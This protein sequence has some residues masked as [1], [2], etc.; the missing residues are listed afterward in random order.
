MSLP[1]LR[2]SAPASAAGQPHVSSA[3]D[4]L[5]R[6]HADFVTNRDRNLFFGVYPSWE[7]AEQAAAAYGAAGYDNA[8]SAQLYRHRVRMD[9]HDYPVLAWLLRSAVEGHRRVLDVGGATGIKWLAFREALAPWP[10]LQWCVQDVPAM[11]DEGRRLAAQRAAAAPAARPERLTFTDRL[12]DGAGCDVLLASGVVQYLPRSLGEQL[13]EWPR[14]GLP[15]RILINTAALHPS[16]GYVTVNSLGTAFC[17]YRVQTQAEL[18]QPLAALGYRPRDAW[19]NPG[20][21]LELPGH[22][23]LSLTAYS[24]LCLDLQAD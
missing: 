24:G 5:E 12:A 21:V 9:V 6:A 15:R 17:P 18:V 13:A 11:V 14:D 8:A 7:L 2:R 1:F 16:R 23:E 22:P 4:P 20:K 10:D 3:D 19:A